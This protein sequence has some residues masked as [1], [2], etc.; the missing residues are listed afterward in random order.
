MTGSS[1]GWRPATLPLLATL[2]LTLIPSAAS[3]A[4]APSTRWKADLSASRLEFIFDQAG[5]QNTG[6]LP[7]FR[8][9]L[10]AY[11]PNSDAADLNVTIYMAEVETGEADRDGILKGPDFLAVK[12]YPQAKFEANAVVA[13]GRDQYVASGRL[14]LRGV[15]HSH[16]LPLEM[17]F[18]ADGQSLRLRGESTIHRLDY[19]IGQGEWSSTE[20]IGNEVKVRFDILL[21]PQPD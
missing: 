8:L 20:W 16:S 15:P 17:V 14:T 13:R 12:E 7:D 6:R 2:I 11:R 1:S 4:S 3:I 18:A 10:S 9:T 19:G 5:A 21:R